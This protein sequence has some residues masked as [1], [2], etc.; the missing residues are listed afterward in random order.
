MRRGGIIVCAIVIAS[1]Y[2]LARRLPPAAPPSQFVVGRHTSL[3]FGPP[4]DYY[5]IFVVSGVGGDTSVERITLTPAADACILPAKVETSSA[6]LGQPVSE[7]FGGMNPCAIPEKELRRELKRCKK[8][9]VFSYAEVAMQAQCGA[10]TRVIRSEILDKDMFDPK[11]AKTPKNTSWTMQ[12]LS[13]LDGAVGPGVMDKPMFAVWDEDQSS[14]GEASS[15]ALRDISTGKY[16][17]LFPSA[18]DKLSGLYLAAEKPVSHPSVRLVSIE[19][20]KPQAAALPPYPGIARLA[21]VEGDVSFS[22]YIGTDG[23]PTGLVFQAGP[24]LLRGAV[25]QAVADW[26]FQHAGSVQELHA[27]MEFKLNCP[28]QPK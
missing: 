20:F 6:S 24:A 8:C 9:L 13:R 25:T 12:L 1:T 4:H 10:Q 16:D 7:L 18:P 28:I 2:A 11:A 14:S 3:D 19:P 21:H 27:T 5:E 23:R 26:S 22:F 17:G 15:A